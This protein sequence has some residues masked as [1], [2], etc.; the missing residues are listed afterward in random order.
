[1]TSCDDCA[2]DD[3]QRSIFLSL[4]G[5]CGRVAKKATERGLHSVVIDLCDSSK[6]DLGKLQAEKEVRTLLGTRRVALLGIELPCNSWSIARR[7]NPPPLRDSHHFVLGLKTK[8]VSIMEINNIGQ[9]F[10]LSA[11]VLHLE[12]RGI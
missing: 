1:M 4:Y 6:N 11:L 10:G 9:Q 8:S 7:G 2:V 12:F 3:T 5:G